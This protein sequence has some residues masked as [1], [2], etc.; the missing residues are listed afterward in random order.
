[1]KSFTSSFAAFALALLP[2]AV[3][4]A[5]QYTVTDL[6]TLGGAFSGGLAINDNGQVTGVATTNAVINGVSVSHAFS[7]YGA[8]RDLGTLGGTYGE[9]FGVNASG[10]VVGSST[11]AGDVALHAFLYTGGAMQDLGTLGGTFSS[12]NGINASGHVAGYSSTSGDVA[13]H[14]FLYDGTMHDLGTFGGTISRGLA[15]ND[16]GEV[17]GG[18]YTN[19]DVDEHAFLYT[20]GMMHDLGKGSLGQGINDSGQVVGSS[21]TPDGHVHA[22]L[23]TGGVMHDLGTLGASDSEARGIN[24][25]G[26]VVGWNGMGGG[27]AFLYDSV[28]G[29]VDLNSLIVSSSGWDLTGA[30]AINNAGQ[31]TGEGTI[32]GQT[33]AFLLTPVPEPSTWALLAMGG[34]ALLLVGRRKIKVARPN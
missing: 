5:A 9:G 8:M 33:H 23:Y 11:T 21:G 22:F 4:S 3:S 27:A 29:M 19:G 24:D 32:G 18:A 26:Q 25:I 20:G 31:I 16:S 34:A 28:H 30:L 12:G 10:Q 17:T 14:A 2:A 7:Y 13:D 15:I 6:G 1:M